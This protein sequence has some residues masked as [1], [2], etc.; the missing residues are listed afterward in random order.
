MK[1]LTDLR[2][3]VPPGRRLSDI[4]AYGIAERQAT[5]LLLRSGVTYGPVPS[6]V[7]AGLQ[8]VQVHLRRLPSSGATK[9]VKPHWHII[10]NSLESPVRQRFSLAH[11]LAHIINHPHLHEAYG[12]LDTPTARLA[13]ERLCD[14]FAAC[15]LMPR[16][17][18]KDA[19]AHGAQDE[20]ELAKRFDVSAQAMHVRIIQL[21]LLEPP[22]RHP[23]IEGIY[24]RD[25]SP[26]LQLGL[27]A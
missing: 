21:G 4:E 17:L 25:S 9:W 7:I 16:P 18:V 12:R 19:W 23:D 6:E 24:F 10:L 5:R 15:L 20:V 11:E 3:L 8:F 13:H 22:E 27:A 1:L 26:A 14:Y 2:R